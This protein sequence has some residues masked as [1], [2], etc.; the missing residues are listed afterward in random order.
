MLRC[1]RVL[2]GILRQRKLL[3]DF[4]YMQNLKTKQGKQ[5]DSQILITHWWLLQG[6][7]GGGGMDEID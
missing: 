3:H 7:V 5:K 1:Y 2:L 4:T 6:K